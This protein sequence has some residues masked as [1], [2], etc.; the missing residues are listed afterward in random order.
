M[1][2]PASSVAISRCKSTTPSSRGSSGPGRRV[3]ATTIMSAPA[4]PTIAI[5]PRSA[6]PT[7]SIASGRSGPNCARI[8]RL[9]RSQ[10]SPT[11]ARRC[12][13]ACA[14]SASFAR[15]DRRLGR[16]QSAQRNNRL[17]A[18]E[19]AQ[20]FLDLVAKPRRDGGPRQRVGDVSRKKS[21]LRA[22][23]EAAAGEFQT[24]E[25]LRPRQ[26]NHGV[27]ELNFTAGAAVLLLQKIEDLRLQN[28]A[29]GQD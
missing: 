11:R 18:V 15:A 27:G 6:L 19:L 8:G 14:R 22:A 1:V 20:D 9:L 10:A 28:I 26:L 16:C 21:D 17:A 29:A 13:S 24:V 23:V 12:C 4:S 3:S 25:G 5:S 2:L 7:N